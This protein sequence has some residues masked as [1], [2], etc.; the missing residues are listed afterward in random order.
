[1]AKRTVL[2]FY[3]LAMLHAWKKHVTSAHA[4]TASVMSTH[5]ETA[6]VPSIEPVSPYKMAATPEPEPSAEMAAATPKPEPVSV[7]AP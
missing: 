4:E 6:H 5:P 7:P 3:A 1:M 2:S